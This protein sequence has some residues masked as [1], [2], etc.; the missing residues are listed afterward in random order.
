MGAVSIKNIAISP[1]KIISAKGGDVLHIMKF[2]DPSFAGF[3]EAYFSKIENNAKKGWKKHKFM[4]LNLVVPLG[5]VKFV[6]TDDLSNFR[7]EIIGESRYVRLT[8]P[9]GIWF[10]FQGLQ[11]PYSLILNLANIVHDPNEIER[12]DINEIKYDW[13]RFI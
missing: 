10:A 1:Q 6:F 4:T 3:E 12:E 7:T 2:K 9:P 8:V 13:S 11:N 5:K